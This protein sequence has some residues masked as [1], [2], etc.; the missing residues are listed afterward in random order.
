MKDNRYKIPNLKQVWLITIILL[1]W[2]AALFPDNDPNE[3]DV[4][5]ASSVN[6]EPLHIPNIQGKCY[7]EVQYSYPDTCYVVSGP[8]PGDFMNVGITEL[9]TINGNSG[10]LYCSFEVSVYDNEKPKFT[11]CPEDII[12]SYDDGVCQEVDYDLPVA[13]DNCG[14][15]S[16]TLKQGLPPGS[17]FPIGVTKIRYKAK[18]DANNIRNCTFYITI[19]GGDETVLE[20]DGS[21]SGILVP[22][23]EANFQRGFY[24]IT[25]DELSASDFAVSDIINSIGFTIGVAQD[26]PVKG[27]MKIYLENTEDVISRIDSTWI[28]ETVSSGDKSHKLFIVNPGDYEWR[29][30]SKIQNPDSTKFS[31]PSASIYPQIEECYKPFNL[32]TNSITTTSALLSWDSFS[33]PGSF[34][35]NYRKATDSEDIP[36]L[37]NPTSNSYNLEVLEENTNYIWS[38]RSV[39]GTDESEKAASSFQTISP[40]IC[41]E[42]PTGLEAVP[43]D[44]HSCDVSW[45]AIDGIDQY[46][47]SCR[48]VGTLQWINF[49]SFENSFTFTNLREGTDYEWRVRCKINEPSCTGL[50]VEA[51]EAF[52]TKGIEQVY[53]PEGLKVSD[54]NSSSVILSWLGTP[55]ADSYEIQYRPKESITWNHVIHGME[56]SNTDDM[57]K[58]HDG[59]VTIPDK[60]GSFDIPFENGDEFI[61]DG[62]GIY[63]AWEFEN[64]SGKLEEGEGNL[65]L[66]TEQNATIKDENGIDIEKLIKSFYWNT[67]ESNPPSNDSYLKA[68]NLRPETRLGVEGEI[69][70]IEV[71][72]VY[73]LGQVAYPFNKSVP[74]SAFIRNLTEEDKSVNVKLDIIDT[75]DNILHTYTE[76]NFP[77]EENCGSTI[78]FPSWNPP[79][80]GVYSVVVSVDPWQNEELVSNNSKQYIQH[81]NKAWHSYADDSKQVNGA[82]FGKGE[83][84]ILCRYHM[85]GC[86]KVIGANIYLHYSAEENPVYAVILNAAGDI[87]NVSGELNPDSKVINNYYSFYFPEPPS[88]SDESY[89]IGL[90]QKSYTDKEYYPVGTQW[91]GSILREEA[92]YKAEL[93]PTNIIEHEYPGRLMIQAEIIPSMPVP[94]IKGDTI[95][96]EGNTNE[97]IA[98]SKTIRYAD[99]TIAVGSQYS[100]FQSGGIQVLGSP[101]VFPNHGSSINAWSSE[102]PTNVVDDFIHL[103]FPEEEK[104]NYIDIYQTLHPGAIETVQIKN[105]QGE[106][107][108]VFD[109]VFIDP[110]A[111]EPQEL[112]TVSRI[113]RIKWSP[114]TDYIVSEVKI[115]LHTNKIPRGI[116]AVAIGVIDEYPNNNLPSWGGEG[117]G[118]GHS[119]QANVE[120]VYTLTATN[121]NNCSFTDSIELVLIKDTIPIISSS[122]PISFCQGGSVL[123]SSDI[124]EDIIWNTGEQDYNIEVNTSGTYYVKYFAGCDSIKS[125][126]ITVTVYE[127]PEP[128][129]TGGDICPGDSALLVAESSYVSYLWTFD[130]NTLGSDSSSVYVQIP[131]AYKLEV[132]DEHGCMGSNFVEALDVQEINPT[133]SGDP[134][135]CPEDS[136][137]LTVEGSCIS[138]LWSTGETS[139]KIIVKTTDIFEVWVTDQY[140][141]IESVSVSTGEYVPPQPFITGSLSLCFGSTSVLDA[142]GGYASYSWE[143]IIGS[144]TST[145]SSTSTI[146]VDTAGTFIVTVTDVNDCIGS[147]SVTTNTDGAVPPTPGPISGPSGGICM[148]SDLEYSIAPVSNANSYVWYVPDDMVIKS[149]QGTTEI[150]VDAGMIDVGIIRV[151]SSNNCANSPT[152]NG[153]TLEVHGT[154]DKPAEISGPANGVCES[155]GINYSVPNIY[156]TSSYNWTVPDGVTITSGIGTSSIVVDFDQSFVTGYISV[157]VD[158][159]CGTS[160]ES[161][162]LVHCN[163]AMPETIYGPQEVAQNAPGIIYSVDPVYGASNYI[164][165]VPNKASIVSGQGSSNIVVNFGKKSGDVTVQTENACG[166]S[167]IQVLA[168]T[169]GGSD[170]IVLNPEDTYDPNDPYS[171]GSLRAFYPEV[172]ASAGNYAS[173]E[174]VTM[175]W[176]LGEPVIK[177]I[178]DD[179]S[180]L[181]Q[182][183]HQSAYEIIALGGIMEGAPFEVEVYPIPTRDN[184]NIHIRSLNDQVNLMVELHDIN[185]NFV[186]RE[187]VKSNEFNHEINLYKYPAA[188]FILTVTDLENNYVRKFKIVKVKL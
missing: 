77:I 89:Y 32:E 12:L 158:N 97:L 54:I 178:T 102:D 146:V 31:E 165:T 64:T 84:L 108:I 18:D 69:D 149:G 27:D 160:E 135:F 117:S 83:G 96:C 70:I 75:A 101:D 95:L 23:G 171:N 99:D 183:F 94:V 136:T 87:L 7:A 3:V 145:L 49:S 188:I 25:P 127:P 51:D 35:L 28:T 24:L 1:I 121:Q 150:T 80:L 170:A 162:L 58:V 66:C 71:S 107:I 105:E 151:A 148:Q 139:Q 154:P 85:E 115:D 63:I 22:Q 174:S 8:E 15:V 14:V 125:N 30:L 50:Y 143:A 67:T 114:L 129:I 57:I 19:I 43:I 92:Y 16:N 91:E 156:G 157:G 60:L 5:I 169:V 184:V 159:A 100:P 65:A 137:E 106:W 142:G 133:I 124:E 36:I 93:D 61:Y 166:L 21:T 181:T 161:Q 185:G 40:D 123:L 47:V 167:A 79:A 59:N 6:C 175:S 187:N 38:V 138:Y 130:G 144:D 168:V 126:E 9:V 39:C 110:P 44:K 2:P 13:I 4:G 122:G 176:T 152:W 128:P 111:T 140:G 34:E 104:I 11:Y 78:S 45:E 74:V 119:Y 72:S 155:S 52:P 120:G 17:I 41:T 186:Y 163:P 164:W 103:H 116:D 76:S 55:S 20:T 131:G 10:N 172:I 173:Y 182:G 179:R 82:G 132:I 48:R 177:T 62:E 112:E 46:D 86:G 180:M 42:L 81:V 53:A 113:K 73:T 68:T 37:P 147:A 88:F 26:V 118:L 29:V 33:S 56:P 141:C 90:A 98:S 109:T 153:R 134:Y